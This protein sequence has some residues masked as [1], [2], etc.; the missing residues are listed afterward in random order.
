M[1]IRNSASHFEPHYFLAFELCAHVSTSQYVKQEDEK[2]LWRK[3]AKK[4]S[5]VADFIFGAKVDFLLLGDPSTSSYLYL[6][7]TEL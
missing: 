5:S 1:K 7:L 4:N 2:T 6:L 3:K